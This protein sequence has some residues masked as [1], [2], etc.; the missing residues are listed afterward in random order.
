MTMN[1][2]PLEG[3]LLDWRRAISGQASI[4]WL[5]AEGLVSSLLQLGWA[6]GDDDVRAPGLPELVAELGFLASA[7]TEALDEAVE[8][9]WASHV[10]H[11][12]DLAL[13]LAEAEEAIGTAP[14][15]EREARLTIVACASLR[16]A[17][18]ATLGATSC[19]GGSAEVARLE[20]VAVELLGFGGH[21]RGTVPL[22]RDGLRLYSL[23]PTD[24]RSEIA[25]IGA[26][27]L[28][29]WG[30]AVTFGVPDGRSIELRATGDR[31][32]ATPSW[33]K[34]HAL[35][36]ESPVRLGLVGSEV[37]AILGEELGVASARDLAAVVSS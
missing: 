20:R 23:D 37:C 13:L 15:G 34:E 36:W 18:Q 12:S 9:A 33:S 16:R 35:S 14:D 6:P 26:R 21:G 7:S 29:D 3:R 25:G 19:M 5:L 8:A 28:C 4:A 24:L 22:V 1:D 30:G 10:D 31:L 27:L 32:T 17:A 2:R 11:G